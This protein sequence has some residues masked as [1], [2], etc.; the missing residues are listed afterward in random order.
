M[1]WVNFAEI[2]INFDLSS[3]QT[4]QHVG[5]RVGQPYSTKSEFVPL[6]PSGQFT[7]VIFFSL[8]QLSERRMKF[9]VMQFYTKCAALIKFVHLERKTCA[10]KHAT[11]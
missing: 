3:G 4:R 9:L 1:L 10:T 8:I 11:L 5:S 6:H 7:K 2:T